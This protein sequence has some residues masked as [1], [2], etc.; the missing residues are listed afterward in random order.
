MNNYKESRILLLS[1]FIIGM[2]DLAGLYIGLEHLWPWLVF[3]VFLMLTG[4]SFFPRIVRALGSDEGY[5]LTVKS[6]LRLLDNIWISMLVLGCFLYT[7]SEV[8][9]FTGLPV[10]LGVRYGMHEY[11]MLI[12]LGLLFVPILIGR[13]LFPLIQ[14]LIKPRTFLLFSSLAAFS[15]LIMLILG[16]KIVVFAGIVVAGFGFANIF[17]ILYSFAINH[18]PEKKHEINFLVLVSALGG[19]ILPPLMTLMAFAAETTLGF[20]VP[21]FAIMYILLL[22]VITKA[23]EV[24]S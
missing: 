15:G 21:L 8:S 3:G 18:L 23:L 7:G 9:L 19:A 11:S 5:D 2:S 16:A 12:T 1:F 20:A 4:V 6:G 22:T 10:L 13:L 14:V 17:R 24:G